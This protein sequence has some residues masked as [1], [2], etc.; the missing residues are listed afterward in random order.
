M[1]PKSVHDWSSEMIKRMF[2]GAEWHRADVAV[3]VRATINRPRRVIRR[4]RLANRGKQRPIDAVLPRV[5]AAPDGRPKLPTLGRTVQFSNTASATVRLTVGGRFNQI[6]V[7]MTE[8]ANV[9]QLAW[10]TQ[11][12]SEVVSDG[13]ATQRDHV[14]RETTG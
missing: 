1:K 13:P 4:C 8:T 6:I 5:D 11:L 14:N 12:V 7:D 2:G 9:T 3:V 10:A